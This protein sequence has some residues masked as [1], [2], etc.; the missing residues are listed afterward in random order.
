MLLKKNIKPLVFFV[1]LALFLDQITK[2]LAINYLNPLQPPTE[3]IGS[4]LRLKLT[5]NP[6]GIFGISFGPTE[7]NHVLSAVGVILFIYI[8]FTLKDRVSLLVFGLLIGGAIGNALDRVR[9]GYV[10]DFIDMGIGDLRWFTY[11]LADAF[12][13]VG[14]IFLLAREVFFKKKL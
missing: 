1:L 3:V 6:Y 4:V 12:L 7:L 2:L 10:I 11:N 9:F 8:A 14:A 13:T 5:F